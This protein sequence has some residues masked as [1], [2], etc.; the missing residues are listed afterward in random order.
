MRSH[1]D[2]SWG[3]HPIRHL[4]GVGQPRGSARI[5]VPA[6]CHQLSKG[7]LRVASNTSKTRAR[8]SPRRPGHWRRLSVLGEFKYMIPLNSGKHVMCAT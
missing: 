3:S 1:D 8:V 5:R 7:S 2:P 6:V 4:P